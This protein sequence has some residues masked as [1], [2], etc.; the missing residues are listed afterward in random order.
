MLGGKIMANSIQAIRNVYD[1]TKGAR[2]NGKPLSDE[3]ITLLLE[4]TVSDESL[5]SKYQRFEKGYAAE[6]LFMRIY[7]LLPWVKTVVPLGQEQFPENS[8]ET[9]QVPDYEIT[10]EAGSE[11]N[12][13]S[14]LIEVK[15]VD[16]DKKTYEL[17]KYKYKVLKEY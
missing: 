4:R 3:E 9:L 15:L 16:G 14:I 10:F 5:I 8:K 2:D 11:T 12:T 7:S 1:I 17:Q 13:S 6:D